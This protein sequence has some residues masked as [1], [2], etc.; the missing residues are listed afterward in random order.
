MQ[1]IQR[2]MRIFD[3]PQRIPRIEAHTDKIPPRALDQTL[4][5]AGLH[6]ACMI[7]DRDLDVFIRR[8]RTYA[9]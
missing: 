1:H 9:L 4:Q 7:L 6:I 3:R 5:L 2:Q 8:E